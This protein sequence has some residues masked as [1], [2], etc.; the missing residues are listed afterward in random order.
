[1]MT[2]DEAVNC[3]ERIGY[4]RALLEYRRH[5][6][7]ELALVADLGARDAYRISEVLQALGY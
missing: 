7:G 5:G 1:M 4:K 3:H 2:Y 6:L